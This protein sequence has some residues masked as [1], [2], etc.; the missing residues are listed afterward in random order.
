VTDFPE[1]VA[2]VAA[3]GEPVR[4]NL[5]LYVV[6]AGEPVSREQA[7]QALGVA[8]HTAKFH[9]DRLADEGLLETEYRRLGGRRGPGAGRPTKL[10]RRSAREVSVSLPPRHYDLAG[11]LLARAID[12]CTRDGEP[13]LDALH[14]EAVELGRRIGESAAAAG[15]PAD[16]TTLLRV[17]AEHG[18]EP[19]LDGPVVTLANCPFAALAHE[20][21]EL[22]CGMNLALVSAIDA[23]LRAATEGAPGPD[24]DAGPGGPPAAPARLRARLDPAPGRC[25]VVLAPENAGSDPGD[26]RGPA[27]GPG[28]DA[29]EGAH[30]PTDQPAP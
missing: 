12:R 19:R 7:A 5:Y 24:V 1:Q 25:C 11:Q 20:H 6:G 14:R 16:G 29:D 18:F 2:G 17:L 27:E 26:G 21:P 10:Y 28:H 22:V 9:L 15:D 4:R 23:G 3:L 8:P 13:V 30:A